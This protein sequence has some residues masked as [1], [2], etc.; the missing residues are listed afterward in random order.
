[1][2]PF[3]LPRAS[4][5]ASSAASLLAE[6]NDP[7]AARRTALALSA[8]LSSQNA[9]GDVRSA[10]ALLLTSLASSLSV[11]GNSSSSADDSAELLAA[12]TAL[13]AQLTG[14]AIDMGLV[15]A[16]S[17]GASAGL[18]RAGAQVVGACLSNLLQASR[19]EMGDRGDGRGAAE[20]RGAAVSAILGSV[21]VSLGA[22]MVAGEQA[23][24]STP[25]F[26]AEVS[27]GHGGRS[28]QSRA[29]QGDRGSLGG[30]G[31]TTPRATTDR[32]DS[33]PPWPFR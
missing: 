11:S 5:Y 33:P 13:P 20:G 32:C 3:V 8:A 24:I 14:E 10:R 21:A 6:A 7:A 26:S 2:L 12:A 16:A 27:A 28:D 22:G 17:I 23:S 25:S 29:S 9:S 30:R 4:S 19:S 31:G 1:M 18:E 15:L